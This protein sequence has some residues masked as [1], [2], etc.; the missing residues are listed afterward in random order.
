[1]SHTLS[2]CD[3]RCFYLLS[4]ATT[5]TT[6][7]LLSACVRR[8]WYRLSLET[9]LVTLP[10]IC[11]AFLIPLFLLCRSCGFLIVAHSIPLVLL[12]TAFCP[13]PKFRSLSA[14][15]FSVYQVMETSATHSHRDYVSVYTLWALA[16]LPDSLAVGVCLGVCLHASISRACA[17]IYMPQ[18]LVGSR[19][20]PGSAWS[21]LNQLRQAPWVTRALTGPAVVSRGL[22]LLVVISIWSLWSFLFPQTGYPQSWTPFFWSLLA[23]VTLGLHVHFDWS[24]SAIARISFL[25]AVAPYMFGFLGHEKGEHDWMPCYLAAAIAGVSVVRVLWSRK[26]AAD[27]WPSASFARVPQADVLCAGLVNGHTRLVLSCEEVPYGRLPALFQANQGARDGH[28][29]DSVLVY[30]AWGWVI[31]ES[32]VYWEMITAMSWAME[33]DVCCACQCVCGDHASKVTR[34]EQRCSGCQGCG[35]CGAG[36][37]CSPSKY[38]LLTQQVQTWLNKSLRLV[39]VSGRPLTHAY[40][41]RVEA[42]LHGTQPKLEIVEI[43]SHGYHALPPVNTPSK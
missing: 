33:V 21:Q 17:S 39:H 23:I 24:Q 14:L 36:W 4:S 13:D 15:L 29:G 31:S 19:V 22:L 5:F 10:S 41:V 27:D 8:D 20:Q 26:P 7:C 28:A 43:L 30:D 6:W 38:S 34:V 2:I 35:G 32:L 25:P 16:L 9:P 37:F 42:V 40:F 3:V 1:M 11:P 12:S 18:G